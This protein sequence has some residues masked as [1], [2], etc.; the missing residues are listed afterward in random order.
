MVWGIQTQRR[1]PHKNGE[2]HDDEGKVICAEGGDPIGYS[3]SGVD[4]KDEV[5]KMGYAN[6]A[7]RGQM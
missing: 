6:G 3:H 2:L 4:E 5:M 7:M 1:V